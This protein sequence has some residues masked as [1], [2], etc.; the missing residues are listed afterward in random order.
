VCP[1]CQRLA[2]VSLVQLKYS[3]SLC[4]AECDQALQG[5]VECYAEIQNA[6][7]PLDDL[8]REI[9]AAK[10]SELIAESIDE[11]QL[12]CGHELQSQLTE[13]PFVLLGDQLQVGPGL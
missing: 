7:I 2:R 10:L 6:G 1:L 3:F 9:F 4:F 8:L 5:I 12:S 13:N 11:Y